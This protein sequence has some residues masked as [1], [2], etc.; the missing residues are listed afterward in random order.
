[1]FRLT[2]GCLISFATSPIL[3]C[4]IAARGLW[5]V[6]TPKNTEH[7]ITD[8]VA[9]YQAASKVDSL[10]GVDAVILEN[11]E[12]VSFDAEGKA[13]RTRYYLYKVLTQKGA[14]EWAD[15]SASW[16]PWHEERP[17]LRARVITADYTVHTLDANT[18]TEVPA[19]QTA[20]DVFSDRR[21]VRAPLPGVTTGSLVEEEQVSKQDAPFF[22]GAIVERFYVNGSVPI[23]HSRLFLDAPSSIPIRYDVRLLPD[24]KPQ[25]TEAGGRV[26]IAFESGPMDAVEDIDTNLP[27]DIPAYS[28]I[29]FSTGVSWQRVAEEYAKI[30]DAQLAGSNIKSLVSQI[31]APHKSRDQKI[32][33][34]LQYLDRGS[35]TLGSSSP[36]QPSFLAHPRNP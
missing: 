13:T 24:L 17:V 25:R 22:G 33:A 18:V 1:M 32:S 23:H 14:A 21:V 30:V 28:N 29:T 36:K 3:F 26:H 6:D 8:P 5:A 12:S 27:G 34:I 19:K 4:A 31:A 2:K 9:L 15:V 11:E 35:A 16:E 7:F 20:D 10:P